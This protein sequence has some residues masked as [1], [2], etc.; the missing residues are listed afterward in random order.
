MDIALTLPP[1][2]PRRRADVALGLVLFIGSWSMA[3]ATLFLSFLILR[4]RQPAWP[5]EG[6]V[7]PSLGL[8]SAGT[9]VLLASSV[10]LASAM[11]ESGTDLGSN[12]VFP[13][14]A[15]RVGL[16]GGAPVN[17]NSF[18]FAW[19]AME[20]RLGYPV[21]LVDAGFAG[22]AGMSGLDVLVVPSA[23]GL[24]GALGENG[25]RRLAQWDNGAG[26]AT[27]RAAWLKRA[28]PIGEACTVDTGTERI[29]GAFAGLD[30]SGALLIED[31]AGRRRTVTFGD[32]ALVH[33][34][35]GGAG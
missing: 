12:S 10:A 8:A 31:R 32:V 1:E 30:E 34:G 14:R 9:A 27:V 19:Y 25:Q 17:G 18:G 35:A 6:V 20:Q 13:L 33:E 28:G 2:T 7:L 26:F 21:T 4:Q 29:A 22:G 24:A 16:L 11:V 3:F 23:G 5:P 15:P